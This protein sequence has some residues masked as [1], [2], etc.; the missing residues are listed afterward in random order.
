MLRKLYQ[1]FIVLIPSYILGSLW[2]NSGNIAERFSSA[3]NLL[4]SAGRISGLLGLLLFAVS[5]TLSV[6]VKIWTKIIGAPAVCKIHHDLSNWSFVLMVLHPVFLAI[7]M[8][9]FSLESGAKLI[10][11]YDNLI[12]LYGFLAVG[13]LILAI[14]STYYMTK[15][16]FIWIWMHR[17][18]LVAYI[19]SGLHLLFVQSD[20]SRYP[21]L[22][23]Y[24]LGWMV[25]GIAAFTYQRVVKF[26]Q[27]RKMIQEN[28]ECEV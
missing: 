14:L 24:L 22:K 25:I 12:N 7:R 15:N 8:A 19:L 13:I 10:F 5:L 23:Y 11:P 4:L 17:S 27:D 21:M 26:N 9:N 20:T 6:R 3:Q 2:L 18:M 16:R 28:E 1:W